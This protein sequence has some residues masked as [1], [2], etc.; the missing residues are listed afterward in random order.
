MGCCSCSAEGNF[1]AVARNPRNLGAEIGFSAAASLEPETP[2]SSPC[3]CRRAAGRARSSTTGFRSH[4]QLLLPIPVL[5][6]VSR[7]VR[8]RSQ[9]R[10]FRLGQLHPLGDLA[11]LDATQTSFSR[12]A[13]TLC[14]KTG[15][16]T[17]SRPSAT[18][19][20]CSLSRPIYPPCTGHF[21]PRMVSWA[22]GQVISLAHS[23]NNEPEAD[24]L[25]AG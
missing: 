2:D 1:L 9:G 5:A 15:C 14:A 7:Q 13:A 8:R 20:M 10:P 16:Y 12:L 23:A 4:P 22:N 17:P 3:Q 25:S 18:P 21:Q 19:S 11:L 24:D 6:G